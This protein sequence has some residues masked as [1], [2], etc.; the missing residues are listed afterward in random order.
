MAAQ[1]NPTMQ[2]GI[3]M[4][5]MR[6]LTAFFFYPLPAFSEKQWNFRTEY[7]II[8]LYAN[9][10]GSAAIGG[11]SMTYGA[12][13]LLGLIQG[14]AEFLP[15][16][17][18]GH[19]AMLQKFLRIGNLNDHLFFDVLL[20]LGTLLA[21]VIT[22]WGE[23]RALWAELLLMLRLRKRPR[24]KKPDAARRR[25]VS[26]LLV[27]T[28]PLALVLPARDA[29]DSLHDNTF[30]IG[31][32]LILTGVLLFASDRMAHGNKSEKAATLG[33]AL[34]VG[35]AQAVAVVPGLSRSGATISTGLLRGFDRTFA[36]RFSFLLSIPAV[37]GANVVTL[38]QAIGEGIDWSLLPM[39]L[40][41]LATAFVS[42]FFALYVL[43][44]LTQKGKFGSFAYYCWGAGLLTLILSLIA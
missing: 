41:G 3:R 44:I 1:D 17:S 30:F 36:V 14:I 20:H 26:F 34:V 28:L 38:V 8:M 11:A 22:F 42:G 24:G 19:L 21:V 29:V 16:S 37:L 13:V 33:D 6:N 7:V 40:V 4:N 23:I 25:M 5:R 35:L 9:R 27:G 32:A 12:A 18:S 15:I 43:R 31:F 2:S 39:Y 10:Y